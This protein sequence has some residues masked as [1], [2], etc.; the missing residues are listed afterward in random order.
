[1]TAYSINFCRI[2]LP[3]RTTKLAVMAEWNFAWEAGVL[4]HD[5]FQAKAE[6]RPAY[7]YEWLQRLPKFDL[8]LIPLVGRSRYSGY[9]PLHHLLPKKTLQ[10]FGLPLL[11]RGMW[12]FEWPIPGGHRLFPPDAEVRLSQAIQYHFWPYLCP[13][14]TPSSFSRHEPIRTLAHHLDFWLPYVDLVAQDRLRRLGRVEIENEKQAALLKRLQEEGPPEF[15]TER[16]TFG[17]YIWWGEEEAKEATREIVE[18]ADREGKLRAILDAVRSNRVE[19]DFSPRWSFARE[20]FERKL[21]RKRSK[22]KVTFVELPETIPVHGPDVEV[23]EHL[24]WQAFFG[25]LNQ[26]ERR[27]TVCLRSGI[28]KANEI[29]SLLGYANHSPVSKALQNIRKKAVEFLDN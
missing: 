29:A 19:E 9:S 15:T 2:S 7:G 22:I 27:I 20:D 17:G 18:M 16:P 23:D 24:L 25:L 13:G 14:A 5:V 10:R 12:P 28:T 6:S 26:K 4:R 8:R 11:K 1:M 21:Y 3:R